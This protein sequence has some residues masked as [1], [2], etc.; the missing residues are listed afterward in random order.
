MRVIVGAFFVRDIEDFILY[1]P[2]RT[3]EGVT[4]YAMAEPNINTVSLFASEIK[5]NVW[6]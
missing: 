6:R 2:S 4:T 1:P 3:R 5:L